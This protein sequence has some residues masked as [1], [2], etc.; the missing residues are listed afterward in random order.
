MPQMQSPSPQK[1]NT[2]YGCGNFNICGFKVPFEVFGKKLSGK[3]LSDL[4][5]KGK[6][7]KIKGLK[8]ESGEVEGRIVLDGT[9]NIKVEQ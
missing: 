6:T 2:A 1:G 9:F 8:L 7:G 3:Q 5:T 4:L